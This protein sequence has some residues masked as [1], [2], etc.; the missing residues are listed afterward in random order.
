M[1]KKTWIVVSVGALA[2]LAVGHQI[3]QGSEPVSVKQASSVAPSGPAPVEAVVREAL[4]GEWEHVNTVW[5]YQC[6]QS[7]EEQKTASGE[8]FRLSNGADPSHWRYSYKGCALT[9]QNLGDTIQVLPDQAC[10][11]VARGPE[12]RYE[13]L[14]IT[15]ADGRS[16]QIEAKG[17]FVVT[18]HD[19]HTECRFD[20]T[21]PVRKISS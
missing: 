4:D 14:K 15:S 3:F 10:A 11:T 9:M 12:V 20:V 19:R 2:A 1:S 18:S 5:R 6:G 13:Q 21:G 17:K 8:N 7:A 16:G